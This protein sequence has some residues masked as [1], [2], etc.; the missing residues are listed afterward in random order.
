MHRQLTRTLVVSGQPPILRLDW[1][2]ETDSVPVD[3]ISTKGRDIETGH[4]P[5]CCVYSRWKDCQSEFSTAVLPGGGGSGEGTYHVAAS[6]WL[7]RQ[8]KRHTVHAASL[9]S[10]AVSASRAAA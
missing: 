7:L 10:R 8:R 9:S 1:I 3:S 6:P 5:E 4:Q 2:E